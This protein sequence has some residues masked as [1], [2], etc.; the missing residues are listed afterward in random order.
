M[1]KNIYSNQKNKIKILKIYAQK[2]SVQLIFHQGSK[3]NQQNNV[4]I[5]ME[6]VEKLEIRKGLYE[7]FTEDSL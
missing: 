2:D 5:L 3:A 4:I 1:V 6:S 7:D